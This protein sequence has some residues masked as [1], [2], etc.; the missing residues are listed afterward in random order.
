MSQ[1]RLFLFTE[2]LQI[3]SLAKIKRVM[4]LR[5]GKEIESKDD[6]LSYEVPSQ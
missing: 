5:T 6:F 4:N 1:V 2:L 3:A